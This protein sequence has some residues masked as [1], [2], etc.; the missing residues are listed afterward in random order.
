MIIFEALHVAGRFF[1]VQLEDFEVSCSCRL[2][3][4]SNGF[5]STIVGSTNSHLS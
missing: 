5:D 3:H 2:E 1:F 4:P